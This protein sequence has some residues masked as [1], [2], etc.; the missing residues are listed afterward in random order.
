[1]AG[2]PV[3]AHLSSKRNAGMTSNGKLKNVGEDPGSTGF[4]LQ[5]AAFADE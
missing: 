3:I 4:A 2:L 1:M 5:A